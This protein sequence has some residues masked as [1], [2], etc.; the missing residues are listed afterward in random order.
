MAPKKTAAKKT[1]PGKNDS[2]KKEFVWSDDEV[3]LLLNVV[4]DYK[5]L[6]ASESVDWESVKTKY[7]DIFERFLAALPEGNTQ[8]C[9][10][11]PH[12][13]DE[14]KLQSLT[15]KLKAIRL[16]FRQA[17]D[18]GRRS[19]HGRV[20]MIYYE[21]CERIWGGSPAT[22]QIDGGIETVELTQGL[23]SLDESVVSDTTATTSSSAC[24]GT[25]QPS[26]ESQLTADSEEDVEQNEEG[27]DQES[28]SAPRDTVIKRRE[29]LN[30]K[31]KNYKHNKMKRKLPVDVQ[32]LG[33]A[34]E[35]LTI[36]KRL[37]EQ[38]DRMNQ[39]YAKNMR[40]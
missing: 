4:A 20:V 25:T 5:A 32:L 7:K 28:T 10:N 38:V 40:R 8:V 3:E 29:F 16:K 1:A 19:G 30:E 11:F 22:E 27:T 9:E 34:Q 26:D 21:L 35:E 24:C 14:I 12:K 2:G 18:S 33:C 23:E 37:V 17:V 6:K 39:R 31:L 36:K 15:S 13:K